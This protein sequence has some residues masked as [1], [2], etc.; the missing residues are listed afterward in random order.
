MP[1]TTRAAVGGQVYHIWNRANAGK[2][3]FAEPEDYALF[4]DV[5]EAARERFSMRILAW[6]AMPDHWH[7]VLWPRQD[8]ELSRSV[9]WLTLTHTQRAH[10]RW[11]TA[12]RGYI[13]QGRF[14]SFPVQ[15]DVH[16]LT[17]CRYV[18]RNAVRA[19]LVRDPAQWRWSSAAKIPDGGR[20]VV[21]S[22]G[23]ANPPA[24]GGDW[25]R[26]ADDPAEVETIRTCL[27]RGRPYGDEEWQRRIAAELGLESAFR[28][29]GRPRVSVRT[30][31]SQPAP[32]PEPQEEFDPTLL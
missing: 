10:A 3:L 18:V 20:S 24:D 28:P 1:R 14:K 8:G 9:G 15:H 29:R 19:G 27:K 13:Y 31:V 6:C 26:E 30:A 11:G 12:G 7:L 22:S 5:L 25:M 4:I 23:P 16:C 17:V 21:T 32:P 2:N